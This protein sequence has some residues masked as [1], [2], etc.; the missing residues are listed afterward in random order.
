MK[1]ERPSLAR[2]GKG[3][4]RSLRRAFDGNE[5]Q[6][7][8]AG[9]LVADFA[10]RLGL[11]ATEV[12]LDL[13]AGARATV[14]RHGGRG[15]MRD[16]V[17]FLDPS[18]FD[19]STAAGRA[20]LAH[21]M[22]HLA[23]RAE[24]G[25][26]RGPGRGLPDLPAAEAEAREMGRRA[27]ALQPL[28]RPRAVLPFGVAAA[29]GGIRP[30]PSTGAAALG[31]EPDS[32]ARMLGQIE[33]RAT[34]LT[35]RMR[36]DRDEVMARLDGIVWDSD[37]TRIMRILDT[38]EV[39]D[40]A[41]LIRSLRPDRRGRIVGETDG[42]HYRNYGR[43]VIAAYAGL[44]SDHAEAFGRGNFDEIDYAGLQGRELIALDLVLGELQR[45]RPR[46][47]AELLRSN[48]GEVLARRM[49]DPFGSPQP[50][51]RPGEESGQEEAA[52]EALSEADLAV[53]RQVIGQAR[54]LLGRVASSAGAERVLQLVRPHAPLVEPAP[55]SGTRPDHG[56]EGAA[57]DEVGGALRTVPPILLRI[58]EERA[59]AN[60][61]DP[62][63]EHTDRAVALDP[64][65]AG[66][67]FAL[68]AHRPVWKNLEYVESL[69]ST[70]FLDWAVR[71]YEAEYAYRLLR[72]MP[73]DAQYRFRHAEGGRFWRRLEREIPIELI[74]SGVYIGIE[75]TRGEDGSYTSTAGDY[76]HL[77]ESGA[78]AVDAAEVL[79]WV[80]DNRGSRG[81]KQ[82]LFA[83]LSR[84]ARE[85]GDPHPSPL[86][87]YVVRRLDTLGALKAMI[88][89][90][91]DEFL[92]QADRRAV[93]D[94]ILMARDEIHLREH[95]ADLM[96]TAWP[97]DTAVT[98]RDAWVAFRLVR[99]LPLHEQEAFLRR[100][101]GEDF[102]EIWNELHARMRTSRDTH[103]F[104]SRDGGLNREDIRA[105]LGATEADQNLWTAAR[106]HELDAQ[107][108]LA[109]GFGLYDFVFAESRRR[110]AWRIEAL[111]PVIERYRLYDARPGHERTAPDADE[112]PTSV[113]SGSGAF[114]FLQP[115]GRAL[116]Y[117][118]PTITTSLDLLFFGTDFL[119]SGRGGGYRI[120]LER[121][122]RL[123]R[124]ATD[125]TMIEFG[126]D[127][128][129][130]EE[131]AEG[132]N[133]ASIWF[134]LGS[135]QMHIALPSLRISRFN[136][137]IGGTRVDMG[138]ISLNGLHIVAR[139][140]DDAFTEA[141]SVEGHTGELKIDSGGIAGP[142]SALA[143][144]ALSVR[145][146]DLSAGMEGEN[147][148]VAGDRPRGAFIPLPFVFPMVIGLLETLSHLGHLSDSMTAGVVWSIPDNST[149][150]SPDSVPPNAPPSATASPA[151]TTPKSSSTSTSP[152]SDAATPSPAKP[153]KSPASDQ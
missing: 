42:T 84:I 4:E 102:A 18:A 41:A 38:Y 145:P 35:D 81:W 146:L 141:V 85:G 100:N 76:A 110:E 70:G 82:E 98:D 13:G 113:L 78:G 46:F 120:D 9:R 31:A 79:R 116:L 119:L 106:R 22:T 135:R 29:D 95:A 130:R 87:S 10:A 140:G 133:T 44:V 150:C 11:D 77:L 6:A 137:M 128:P 101:D 72:A 23:Q 74:R 118:L 96:S 12:Q 14:G 58:A 108:R 7:E 89:G 104:V 86:L 26:G 3:A 83:Q 105:R 136:H 30:Q 134:E 103:L 36:G 122:M 21:E 152:P 67:F 51:R 147:D 111:A 62:L 124:I 50:E 71:D 27:A 75:V 97:V 153:A 148:S 43:S 73:L 8:T 107:V 48:V 1:L 129:D 91:P 117:A 53:V 59:A 80:E 40:A 115:L 93:F 37:V 92:F 33:T 34:A 132:E 45:L 56:D 138:P 64:R 99:A 20:L 109:I 127:D 143:F 139:Y 60:L 125:T 66:L 68:I 94:E 126:H 114:E 69:L 16:G 52:D 142:G 65:N 24:R 32:A 2:P 39:A 112:L 88:D 61:L 55:R 15:L 57:L 17:A 5:R 121:A 90:L 131:R 28:G 149:K 49:A 144:G 19:P 25:P 47:A 63:L 123:A 54:A 151:A